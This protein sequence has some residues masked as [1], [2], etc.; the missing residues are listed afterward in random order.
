MKCNWRNTNK[1]AQ[2][3][4]MGSI[5]GLYPISGRLLEMLDRIQSDKKNVTAT[6]T[7]W[8]WGCGWSKMLMPSSDSALKGKGVYPLFTQKHSSWWAQ[9]S[10]S[11]LPSWNNAVSPRD[12]AVGDGEWVAW[13]HRSEMKSKSPLYISSHKEI[14]PPLKN[15][16]WKTQW[17][18]LLLP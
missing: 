14:P 17:V 10:P 6:E 12:C 3:R 2:E 15:K 11:T 4:K 16:Y 8:I 7:K 9:E 18:P 5:W 1:M 13:C